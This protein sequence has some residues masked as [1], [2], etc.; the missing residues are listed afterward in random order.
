MRTRRLKAH[1]DASSGFYHCMSRVVDRQFIFGEIEKEHFSRLMRQYARFC[2]IQILTFCLMGNHFHLLIEVPKRPES[3]PNDAELL[4]RISAI[5]PPARIEQIRRQLADTSLLSIQKDA[6][7]QRFWQRMGDLSQYL[8]ELKQR[9]SQWHN[10]RHGRRGTLWE[11][12]FKSVLIGAE[13]SA[14]S[15]IAAYIDLNPVR[16]GLVVD[17]ARYRWSGYGQAMAGRPEALR[18]YQALVAVRDGLSLN[19]AQ[20]LKHYRAG[21][22]DYA[23][24]KGVFSSNRSRKNTDNTALPSASARR[25]HKPFRDPGLVGQLLHRISYFT[26]GAVIGTRSFVE[27]I[28]LHHQHWL[29]RKRQPSPHPVS[30]LETH[31]LFSL[32]PS[33]ILAARGQ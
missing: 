24:R 15:T 8:K 16:A 18:G 32:R 10:L 25:P 11:E 2:G 14:L 7:R 26:N 20:A 19:P 4:Q 33:R 6:L 28:A 29:Q 3:P 31:S 27:S 30:N 21:L 1:P 5:Y 22:F 23:E 13:G 9:F 12:R 17:P